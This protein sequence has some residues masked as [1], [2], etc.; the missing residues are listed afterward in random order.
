VEDTSFHDVIWVCNIIFSYILLSLSL[1]VL[2]GYILLFCQDIFYCFVRIY[3]INIAGPKFCLTYLF[4]FCITEKI[5]IKIL[6]SLVM[7]N[8]LYALA[9]D[10]ITGESEIISTKACILCR[11]KWWTKWGFHGQFGMNLICDMY[12]NLILFELQI[13]DCSSIEFAHFWVILNIRI[14]F[15]WVRWKHVFRSLMYSEIEVYR[16]F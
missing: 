5:G 16:Q 13:E 12:I 6:K 2:S 10:R 15:G 8:W 14:G 1:T 11:V 4:A 7:W 3:S 9:W